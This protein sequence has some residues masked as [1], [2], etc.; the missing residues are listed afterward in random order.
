MITAFLGRP[1]SCAP[2]TSAIFLFVIPREPEPGERGFGSLGNL[3]FRLC[4]FDCLL[5]FEELGEQHMKMMHAVFALHRI[6]P[7]VIG[8]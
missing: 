6:S 4:I 1:R 5:L 8:R 2:L 7:A 3:S